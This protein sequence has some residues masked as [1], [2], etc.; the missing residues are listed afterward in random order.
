VSENTGGLQSREVK[1]GQGVA[2]DINAN[3]FKKGVS[4]IQTPA[5]RS[6]GRGHDNL[7]GEGQASQIHRTTSTSSDTNPGGKGCGNC[8]KRGR[9][10]QDYALIG[11]AKLTV[12]KELRRP[13]LIT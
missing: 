9:K 3:H 12:K 13:N 11:G 10:L 1:K 4:R 2:L 7:G 5:S 8:I 6:E